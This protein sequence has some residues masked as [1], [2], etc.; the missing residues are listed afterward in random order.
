MNLLDQHYLWASMVWGAIASGYWIYGW[1]QKSAW[2]LVAG[3]AMMAAS[4]FVASALLMSLICIAV[5]FAVWWL[6][7]QGY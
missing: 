7:K 3:A 1:R 6:M 5:M 2:P 4:I